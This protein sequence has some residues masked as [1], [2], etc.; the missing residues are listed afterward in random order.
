MKKFDEILQKGFDY[1]KKKKFDEALKIYNELI[2]RDN[3]NSQ[4]LLFLGTLYLQINNFNLAKDY[5][6]QALNIDKNNTLAINNLATTYEK[7][8]EKNKAIT[9]LK[10]SI[11]ISQNNPETFFRIGNLYSVEKKY[12]LA[13][14]NYQKAIELK[15]NFTFAYQNLGSAQFESKF[16]KKS[17]INY[18]KALTLNKNF[19][20]NYLNLSNALLKLGEFEQALKYCNDVIK[21]DKM[22]IQANL[23]KGDINLILKNFSRAIQNY[24]KIIEIKPSHNLVLGK[25][26]YAKMFVHDW[27]NFNKL[28]S[29]VI[30]YVSKDQMVIHPAIFLSLTDQPGLHLKASKIYAEQFYTKVQVHQNTEIKKNSKI[31]IGYFSADFF[32]HATLRLMMDIFMYHDKSKFNIYGFGYGPKK[33]D[34]YTKK[35]KTYLHDYHYVEEMSS[36]EIY[37]LCKKNHINIAID[38]KGYTLNNRL[39]IFK[40]RVAPIQISFLGYPGTTG[41]NTMDYIIAD[42][43]VIPEKYSKFYSEKVLFLPDCYQPNI[44][45]KN[46]STKKITKED[47]GLTKDKFIFCSF[48]FNYKITEEMFNLWIEILKEAPNSILWMLVSNKTAQNNLEKFAQTKGVSA[49]RIIFAR[50]VPESEH[51]NRMRFADVFLDSFPVNAHTTASDALR[52]GVPVVTL[53]GKSFASRVAASIIHQ[54]DLDDLVTSSTE[55]YKNKAIELYNNSI[56]LKEIK[57]KLDNNREKSALFDSKKF[58]VNL[59]KIYLEVFK[60]KI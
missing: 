23:I 40:K 16:Y 20:P 49:E 19:I 44:K 25:L 9:L 1:Q 32:D 17:V 22:N 51:L 52:M 26:L 8:E 47:F 28:A 35:L 4:L 15:P 55:E 34:S 29:K 3:K 60:K 46:I 53:K 7:L 24:E 21:L 59:E 30:Q 2:I 42:K 37:S 50:Y 10:K 12:E 11:E 14:K 5:L 36:D 58:T 18:K 31:N 33:E 13:I 39:E 54:F 43:T 41:L 27:K 38:L 6:E 45:N 57:K 56:M 48:N